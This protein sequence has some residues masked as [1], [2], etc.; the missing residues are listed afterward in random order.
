MLMTFQIWHVTL[1]KDPHCHHQDAI[2]S[3]AAIIVWEWATPLPIRS[4][5]DPFPFFRSVSW[6]WQW[7]FLFCS[8]QWVLHQHN[9]SD[10]IPTLQVRKPKPSRMNHHSDHVAKNWLIQS[11][12][13][14]PNPRPLLFFFFFTKASLVDFTCL[15]SLL[16]VLTTYSRSS[17]NS[18]V[19]N[20][21]C[22]NV[23]EMT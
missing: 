5:T 21:I 1:R 16:Q 19:F 8:L 6:K 7:Y 2:L 4:C 22:Y 14:A 10:I 12:L 18:T 15:W 3:G 13:S 20:S 9:L 17:K 23:D 11:W